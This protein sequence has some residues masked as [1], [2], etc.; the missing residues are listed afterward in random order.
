MHDTHDQWIVTRQRKKGGTIEYLCSDGDRWSPKRSEADPKPEE[1]AKG[2]A[3]G[4]SIHEHGM[5]DHV[6]P[7]RYDTILAG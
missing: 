5:K 3:N 1:F 6:D 2:T 7:Y 4:L